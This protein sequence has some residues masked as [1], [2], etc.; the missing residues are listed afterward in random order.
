MDKLVIN[1][2]SLN[3]N[4]R[5]TAVEAKLTSEKTIVVTFNEL[6]N[7]ETVAGIDFV[8]KAGTTA[9]TIATD[10]DAVKG[11]VA[12]GKTVTITLDKNVTA[13]NLKSVLTVEKAENGTFTDAVG[14]ESNFKS[15]TVAQ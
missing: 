13:E 15:I 14:N 7:T 1:N 2:L 5:P 11:A 10:S 12:S 6:L 4:I 3:E 8:V 9:L